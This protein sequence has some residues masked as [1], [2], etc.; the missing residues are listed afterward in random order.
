MTDVDWA[1]L[2]KS[3]Y[4]VA[5]VKIA[6]KDI[7]KIPPERLCEMNKKLF[8]LS[9]LVDG[10]EA[11]AKKGEDGD[12][13]GNDDDNGDNNKNKEEN[14]GLDKD[15]DDA[16]TREDSGQRLKTPANQQIQSKSTGYRT[17]KCA[18]METKGDTVINQES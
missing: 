13:D 10:E 11:K 2:F 17:V 4:E 5:R 9:F 16:K 8:L 1:T 3:F 14:D 18:D 6:C 15:S 7:S 12:D